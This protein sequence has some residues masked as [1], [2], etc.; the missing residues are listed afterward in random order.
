M[1]P[2]FENKPGHPV[3][4][5]VKFLPEIQKLEGPMGLKP[6]IKKH[7]DIVNHFEVENE[8]VIVDLDY[9]DDY[10]YY[11]NKYN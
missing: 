7:N 5:S 9:Y 4:I 8:K 1:Q 6:F 11:K 2:V 3:I 10:L